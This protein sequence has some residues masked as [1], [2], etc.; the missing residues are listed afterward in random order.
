MVYLSDG[1]A[2]GLQC[3]TLNLTHRNHD[4][5]N[6]DS[7]NGYRRQD[8]ADDKDRFW[9]YKLSCAGEL[10]RSLACL[11]AGSIDPDQLS[12]NRVISI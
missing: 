8:A 11:L 6:G 10:A 9:H 2:R 5:G 4:E 3:L 7:E 12:G 1:Q